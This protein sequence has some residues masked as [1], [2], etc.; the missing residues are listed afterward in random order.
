MRDNGKPRTLNDDEQNAQQEKLKKILASINA[1]LQSKSNHLLYVTAV[2]TPFGLTTGITIKCLVDSGASKTLIC[3]NAISA[4]ANQGIFT[5]KPPPKG[6]VMESALQS[7]Y[8][9]ILGTVDVTFYFGQTTDSPSIS[10]NVYVMS[11]LNQVCFLGSDLMYDDKIMA[12]TKDKLIINPLGKKVQQLGVPPAMIPVKIT[13][14]AVGTNKT[15]L[16]ISE[17]STKKQMSLFKS[18]CCKQNEDFSSATDREIRQFFA[19][20]KNLNVV[21]KVDFSPNSHEK[22]YS[23][24]ERLTQKNQPDGGS[25]SPKQ[26][27]QASSTEE[28]LRAEQQQQHSQVTNDLSPSQEERRKE[29]LATSEER[30]KEDI[31]WQDRAAKERKINFPSLSTKDKNVSSKECSTKDKDALMIPTEEEQKEAISALRLKITEYSKSSTKEARDFSGEE[32]EGGK[33]VEGSAHSHGTNEQQ[34]AI[35]TNAASLA[36]TPGNHKNPSQFPKIQIDDSKNRTKKATSF[37]EPFVSHPQQTG[38]RH[39]QPA[40]REGEILRR[41]GIKNQFSPNDHSN[42][43]FAEFKPTPEYPN[44]FDWQN[45]NP[46]EIPCDAGEKPKTDAEMLDLVDMHHLPLNEQRKY[47]DLL[48]N[49][50]DIFSRYSTDIGCTHLFQGM[51]YLKKGLNPA[52]FQQKHIPYPMHLRGKITELLQEMLHAGIIRKAPGPVRCLTNMHVLLKPSGRLRLLLDA[53]SCNYYSE[54]LAAVTTFDMREVLTKMR[55]KLVSMVDVSQSFFNIPLREEAMEFFSFL[56][57]DKTVFQ[58]TRVAQGHHNSPTFQAHAMEAMLSIPSRG[59][60]PEFPP[61]RRR[62][63]H[64]NEQAWNDQPD[65]DFMPLDSDPITLFNVYDDLVIASDKLTEDHQSEHDLHREALQHMFNKIRKARMKLRLE[66]LQLAPKMLTVLGMNFDCKYLHIPP[67]RFAA[68]H[69][70]PVNTP[71]RAKGFVASL[72]YFRSFCPS[73]SALAY[74]LIKFTKKEQYGP[75]I[76]KAKENLLK[77]MENSSKIRILH[78]HDRLILS[79]D[80]SKYCAAATLE[81][82]DGGRT[83]LVAS[84]SKLFTKSEVNHDIFAKEAA[85]IVAALEAFSF[86]LNGVRNFTLRTDVRGIIYI[87]FTKMK[88]QVSYRLASELSRHNPTIIHI[89]TSAHYVTDSLS[90]RTSDDDKEIVDGEDGLTPKE[91]ESILKSLF[92]QHG[93]KFTMK[94]AGEIISSE[95]LKSIVKRNAEPKSLQVPSTKPQTA[96]RH[97]IVRPNFVKQT[98][99][100]S[101]GDWRKRATKKK[102]VSVNSI[103]LIDALDLAEENADEEATN[104]VSLPAIK[105]AA[106]AIKHGAM[107]VADFKELQELDHELQ[108]YIENKAPSITQNADGLYLKN[109]KIYLPA[110]LVRSAVEAL[111]RSIPSWHMPRGQVIRK[112]TARYFRKHLRRE[113]NKI[114]SECFI[115]TMGAPKRMPSPKLHAQ[116]EP[117]QPREAWYIDVMDLTKQTQQVTGNKRHAIIAIDAFSNYIVIAPMAER[118]KETIRD[119]LISQVIAPF[120]STK[121]IISDNESGVV[122]DTVQNALAANNI[123]CHLISPHAP[124]ANKAERA[125][126]TVKEAIRL[127]L[128]NRTNYTDILPTIVQ[129]INS[130]PLSS[131][132]NG[133]SPELM[134]FTKELNLSESIMPGSPNA[135]EDIARTAQRIRQAAEALHQAREKR[136]SHAN[137]LRKDRQFEEGEIVFLREPT[138]NLGARLL[139]PA[140]TLH[141]IRRKAGPASYWLDNLATKAAVKRHAA[142]IFPADVSQRAQL[143]SPVWDRHIEATLENPTDGAPALESAA[144]A[145]NQH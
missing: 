27:A 133:V 96:S 100:N 83:E 115:C 3:Y 14:E 71:R 126:G 7:T 85:T 26:A 81:V 93:R 73:F 103:S 22:I 88:N 132:N 120:G 72:A 80:A 113:I 39:Q 125:I 108:E 74:T 49:N 13:R 144:S 135:P 30:I 130:T 46:D 64:A 131:N 66:K 55:G 97:T 112:L 37:Q 124:W 38:W 2:V 121:L 58:L 75:H 52:D 34:N 84:F 138:A 91:A 15:V 51:V 99:A 82:V 44:I 119:T 78:Q 145:A 10:T 62:G 28:N 67:K 114:Y 69:D 6:V 107:Q 117:E 76:E 18:L 35:A 21:N 65:P 60:K 109:G 105:A 122:S 104:E 24:Q 116:I 111:H 17:N 20:E 95:V 42:H 8:A 31:L 92:I 86:Y 94:E 12:I 25:N 29:E 140:G 50:L 129:A 101:R 127:A 134:F 45:N 143:L 136:R 33:T 11:G 102:R 47:R 89:P 142:F 19:A 141:V 9:K 4:Q 139:A 23:I 32:I 87:R 40:G 53:R 118:T 123:A 41:Q 106:G 61:R 68:W 77:H 98:A 1:V 128:A 70:M 90:R 110:I 16:S 63:R 137:R 43:G 79:T 56:G 57:P 48:R 54:R 36:P 5:I 59:D